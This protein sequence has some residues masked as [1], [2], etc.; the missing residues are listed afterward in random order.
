MNTRTNNLNRNERE[1]LAILYCAAFERG[2]LE[3]INKVLED[4]AEDDNLA[5]MI[6]QSSL[7]LIG[8]DERE[9]AD[10]ILFDL[11]AKHVGQ[12]VQQKVSNELFESSEEIQ[13]PTVTVRSI[14]ANLQEDSSINTSVR[15]EAAKAQQE[16]K[17]GDVSLPT[18]LSLRGVENLLRSVGLHLSESAKSLFRR[19]AIF[20]SMGLENQEMRLAAT[21]KQRNS[22]RKQKKNDEERAKQ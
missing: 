18:D 8:Q 1:R 10:K 6:F 11:E 14:L 15:N 3:L 19:V 20:K 21:R 17:A 7:E 12:I 16:L 13:L 5:Q 2:D 22:K 4:A 9:V